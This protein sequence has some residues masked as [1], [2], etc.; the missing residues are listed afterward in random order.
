L[1]CCL[2]EEVWNKHLGGIHSS[3]S[4]EQLLCVGV[5]IREGEPWKNSKN[6]VWHSRR[7]QCHRW[8]SLTLLRR[9]W[10]RWDCSCAANWGTS[11]WN[12]A[13]AAKTVWFKWSEQTHFIILLFFLQWWHLNNLLNW[14]VIVNI[15]YVMSSKT[16][17]SVIKF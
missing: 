7:W 16:V 13:V 2:E 5:W 4:R 10:P 15:C 3:H 8:W 11:K 1:R 17:I 14:C 6:I 12:L 9:L